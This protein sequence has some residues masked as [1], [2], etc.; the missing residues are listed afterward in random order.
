MT[1]SDPVPPRETRLAATIAYGGGCRRLANDQQCGCLKR[2]SRSFSQATVCQEW[3]SM[4]TLLTVEN[5]AIVVHGPVGCISSAATMNIFNRSGLAARGASRIR[6]KRWFSTQL[7]ESDVIHGGE[8]KLRETLKAI[9]ARYHPEAIFVFTTCVSGI[10]GDPVR[11]IIRALQSEVNSRLV[12]SECEGFKT[13]VWATGF[14]AAFHGIVSSLLDERAQRFPELVNVVSPLTIGR[15]DELEI[16]RLFGALG[17]SANFVP[18]YA[19]IEGLRRTVQAAATTATCLTYGD[20]FARQL[21]ERHGV[22]YTRE[23]M[24]LGIENTNRWLRAL[25]P[26]VKKEQEVEALIAAEQ[27]RIQPKL[28]VLRGQLAGK[29]VFISAGQARAMTMSAL[30][31]ELGFELVGT[32]VYHYDD[33]VVESVARLARSLGDFSLNVANVQPFEQANLLR[34]LKPDLYLA[35]EMTTGWAAKQGIPTMMIYDYG[36]TYLGYE[37]TLRIGERLVQTLSNPSFSEKLRR[38]TVLPYRESRYASDPFK[39]LLPDNGL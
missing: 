37:G 32:T 27:A 23:V 3:Y 25:A 18:C 29:R 26:L 30:A 13:A 4:F 11:D 5:T 16:E 12:L 39:Y 24:P 10:I 17:L 31:S 7:T 14:D 9:D 22:P 6:S 2:Q 38:H 20:Y 33:V 28:D 21:A 8:A 36:M 15:L 1:L 19:T 35:D 34:R